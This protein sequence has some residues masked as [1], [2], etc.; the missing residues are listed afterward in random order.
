MCLPF[1]ALITHQSVNATEIEDLDNITGIYQDRD[2]FIWLS[3][4]QG[5]YRYDGFNVLRFANN[6][7]DWHVPFTWVRSISPYQGKLLVSTQVNGLYS[8]DPKTGNYERLALP[9][10]IKSPYLATYCRN[11]I[12]FTDKSTLYSFDL[13]TQTTTKLIE[14][15]NV[16]EII[17]TKGALYVISDRSI[18]L[19]TSNGFSTIYSG[20]IKSSATLGDS[21]VIKDEKKLITIKGKQVISQQTL[22]KNITAITTSHDKTAILATGDDGS[23]YQFNSQTLEPIAANY[24]KF[25]NSK[26]LKLFHDNSKTLWALTNQGVKYVAEIIVKNTPIAYDIQHNTN[27]LLAVNDDLLIGTFGKGLATLKPTPWLNPELN[28]SLPNRAKYTTTMVQHGNSIIFGTLDGLWHYKLGDSSAS[29]LKNTDSIKI[30]L[31]LHIK[32][33]LLYIGTNYA[34]VKKYDLN[35]QKIVKT[36]DKANGLHNLEVID[37][38]TMA[39]GDL[40]LATSDSVQLYKSQTDT[41][42][43]IGEFTSNKVVSLAHI[44]NKIFAFTIGSGIYVYDLQGILLA[45]LRPATSFHYNLVVG[46]E[47]WVAATPGL[48]RLDPANYKLSVV[49]GTEDKNFSSAP[50]LMGEKIFAWHTKGLIEVDHKQKNFYNAKIK[51]SKT[52]VSGQQSLNSS[53]INVGSNKDVITLDLASLD[54]RA[55]TNKQ[56]KYRLNDNVWTKVSGN[57]ITLA[58]L[59]SGDYTLEVM[60]TNSLGQW[61]NYVAYTNIHMAYP[62]YWTP[63]IRIIYLLLLLAL[64]VL[65]LWLIYTRARSI[66]SVYKVL[67]EDLKNRG[68]LSDH[69]ERNINVAIRLLNQGEQTKASKL[70][71]EAASIIADNK[72]NVA[73]SSLNHQSLSG[74]IEY[75]VDFWQEKYS[76]KVRTQIDFDID[77]LEQQ[78]QQ[79]IYRIIYSAIDSAI[80]HSKSNNFMVSIKRF[81]QKLWLRIED[82]NDYFDG[83]DS[84]IDFNM[85]MYTIRKIAARHQAKI[86]TYRTSDNT[87]QLGISFNLDEHV[88]EF[89]ENDI[90]NNI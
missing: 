42:Q 76:V 22:A 57:Q 67:D 83:F 43:Q 79:S 41:V 64:M 78:L 23:V 85:A 68:L 66:S 3:G 73:P 82:D 19:N 49:L 62:W 86:N 74:G 50:V 35:Q 39:N 44:D 24:P 2:D 20:D 61:S 37:I 17:A 16:R 40:W 71:S 65:S 1:L 25:S 45:R 56:F 5:L 69:L 89:I 28:I 34:G 72:T 87:S 81:N 59:S 18:Q 13:N 84:K 53:V 88:D 6:S 58:G 55:N 27:E 63:Q 90:A 54:Y 12:Y 10:H 77:N 60:G 26:I 29:R 7:D 21:L 4:Q 38:V 9:S 36:I 46:N 70:L 15:I 11:Q 48:Y 31:T 52:A 8:L 51:I 30:V 33:S 14:N 80:A 32:D 47:V 75:L